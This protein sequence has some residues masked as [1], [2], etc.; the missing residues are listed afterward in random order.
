MG[1][2]LFIIN[3]LHPNFK[4]E[5]QYEPINYWKIISIILI[6][7]SLILAGFIVNKY[8]IEPKQ[9]KSMQDFYNVGIRDGQIL[10]LNDICDDGHLTINN[11][12]V[13]LENICGA[14]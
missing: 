4:M 9:I 3:F 2:V 6:I 13:P 8:Y 11:T 1:G 10:M 14:R 5:Q 12:R 7:V